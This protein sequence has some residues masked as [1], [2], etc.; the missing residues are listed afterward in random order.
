[1]HGHICSGRLYS[2]G[3]KSWRTRLK[4]GERGKSGICEALKE[5]KA[6]LLAGN[7]LKDCQKQVLCYEAREGTKT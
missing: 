2:P 6:A 4:N 7:V 3:L 1:M 5:M